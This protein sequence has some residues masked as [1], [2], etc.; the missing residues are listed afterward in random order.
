MRIISSSPT[1]VLVERATVVTPTKVSSTVS[2]LFFIHTIQWHFLQGPIFNIWIWVHKLILWVSIRNLGTCFNHILVVGD[3]IISHVLILVQ[4]QSLVLI[5]ILILVKNFIVR[6]VTS[7][8]II[9]LMLILSRSVGNHR[10]L[11]LK[12]HQASILATTVACSSGLGVRS[13][14]SEQFA[15]WETLIVT[16]VI[17]QKMLINFVHFSIFVS[18]DYL[19]KLLNCWLFFILNAVTWLINLES[20]LW[21]NFIFEL[22]LKIKK[23][24]RTKN[25][26]NYYSI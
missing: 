6:A 10:A 9:H 11:L 17:C 16:R 1:D 3:K 20:L 25:S 2:V 7:K 13:R 22:L 15:A 18:T 5:E 14:Q 23:D 26:F 4:I 19:I 24:N 21:I 12:Q 8:Q